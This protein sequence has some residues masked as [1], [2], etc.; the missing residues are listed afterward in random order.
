M[1]AWLDELSLEPGPPFLPM[2]TRALDPAALL[3]SDGERERYLAEKRLHL[4][5][6]RAQVVVPPPSGVG[7]EA[8]QLVAGVDD[9]EAAASQVQE[10]LTVLLRRDDGWYLEGG[11]VCF[12]SRW[13]FP[14]KVGSHIAQVHAPVPHYADELAEKVDRFLDRLRPGRP[15]WRRLWVFHDDPSLHQPVPPPADRPVAP[16]PEGWWVRSERQCLVAL[17]ATGGILFV[18]RTQLLPMAGLA[19]RPDVARRMAA[20]MASWSPELAAYRA[21]AAAVPSLIRWLAAL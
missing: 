19:E 14:S 8:A 12:P 5:L 20:A 3:I 6:H 18:I 1:V 7:R 10:D 17:P 16:V 11:V 15:A 9:L 13:D 4:R 2:G 21:T